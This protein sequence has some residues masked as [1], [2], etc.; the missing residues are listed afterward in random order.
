MG[1]LDSI[2]GSIGY[3]RYSDGSSFYNKLNTSFLGSTD[4]LKIALES[5]I[6]LPLIEIRAK[7]LAKAEFFIE[8]PN[9]ELDKEHPIIELLNNPNPHQS[10]Q[11]FLKQ[12]TWYKLCFG[13]TYQKP[14]KAVGFDVK[15]IY[16][17]NPKLI[18]FPNNIKQPY[19]FKEK[20]IKDYYDQ[21]FIY[22][23][24]DREK[25]SIAL[26]DVIPFY[27]VSNGLKS[28]K[29]SNITSP[30]RIAS[31]IK[32]VSN[33]G[34]ALDAENVVIQSNGRELFSSDSKGGNLG[35][36]L[37]MDSNDREDIEQKIINAGLGRFKKRAVTT[38]RPINWQSL[39]IKANELGLHE[40]IA[41]N[42]EIVRSVFEISS[43]VYD[44]F[45]KNKTYENQKQALIGFYQGTMQQEADD[46]A[47]SWTSYFGLEETPIKASFDHLPIMQYTEQVKADKML[48][49]ATA[50][51]KLTRAGLNL[52]QIE[53]FA[54]NQG[55]DIYET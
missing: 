4:Y 19:I 30:S 48:K 2:F 40:A 51:E 42:A 25:K 47:N 29:E 28:E 35:S 37:P 52:D 18:E 13:W 23:V 17:L 33:T 31:A 11:D 7:A 15:H 39:H 50:I 5:P 43:E 27:D 9:G 41:N 1:L 55:I 26:K 22:K 36:S 14:Y 34:L 20:D 46:F 32:A 24:S 6:L 8:N 3:V 45:T 53:E 21:E 12:Y 49:I 54:S 10:K 38:N 44:A 16:N